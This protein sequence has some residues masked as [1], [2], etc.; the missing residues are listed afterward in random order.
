[1]PEALAQLGI[2]PADV[3]TLIHT[4][5][6]FDHWGGDLTEDGE[7]LFPNATIY[8]HEREI[9]YWSTVA[10]RPL[11][12]TVRR[13]FILLFEAGRVTTVPG[14]QGISSEIAVTETA[15]HTP[16]HLSVVI[17]AGQ[18]STF[19]AGDAAHHPIQAQHP[20]W[21]VL[22]DL[23]PAAAAATRTRMFEALAGSATLFAAGHLPTA[24]IRTCSDG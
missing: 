14:E 8:V 18:E 3:T 15:G 12:E 22:F 16:G 13:R 20:D 1:M 11:G 21:N 10:D 17:G 2:D 9:E 5:L 23:D 7:P 19:I 24:R 6:H 4:H